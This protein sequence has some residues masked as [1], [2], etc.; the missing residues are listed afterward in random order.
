MYYLFVS[1]S[2]RFGI[3]ADV[4]TFCLSHTALLARFHVVHPTRCRSL[5]P[6]AAE[7]N[8]RQTTN[9]HHL[10]DLIPAELI[11]GRY[12]HRPAAHRLLVDHPRGPDHRLLHG[13][14]ER[15][16]APAPV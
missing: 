16:P 9:R 4:I 5:R 2:S 15:R 14:T 11:V 6:R 12:E 7:R 13:R 3:N 1:S 10:I 8:N